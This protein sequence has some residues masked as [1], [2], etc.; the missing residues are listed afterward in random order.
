MCS[1]I[2]FFMQHFLYNFVSSQ[3]VELRLGYSL[4]TVETNRALEQTLSHIEIT[5][6]RLLFIGVVVGTPVEHKTTDDA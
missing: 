5:H 3:L 4:A 1:S 6:V 2:L